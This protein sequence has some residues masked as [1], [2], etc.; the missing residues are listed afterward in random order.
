[1]SLFTFTL[2]IALQSVKL[3]DVS[4][5]VLYQLMCRHTYRL[6]TMAKSMS[7]S[8]LLEHHH[9][10]SSPCSLSA[11]LLCVSLCWLAFCAVPSSC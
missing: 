4:A 2:E 10:E 7:G 1:M 9:G 8:G 5:I 3:S 6:V 11:L